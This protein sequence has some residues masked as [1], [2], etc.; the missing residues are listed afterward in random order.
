MKIAVE[1]STFLIKN[2]TGVEHYT[3]RLMQAVL[4]LDRSNTYLMTYMAFGKRPIPDFNLSASNVQHRRVRWLPGKLYNLFLRLPFGLPIDVI[5]GIKPD[6]FFFPNF[7]LWPLWQTKRSVIVIHDL[8]Y[9]ELPEVLKTGHHVWFLQKSITR[10]IKKASRVVAVSEHT[11]RQISKYYGVPLNEIAVVSPSLDKNAFRPA[12]D[13]EIK[14]FKKRHGIRDNYI[15]YF[16]TLEPRKNI[17]GLIRSYRLLPAELRAKYQLVLAGGKGWG[18]A[19]I[20][21]ELSLLQPGE[22]V[23]TGYVPQDE[24]HVVYSG[25]TVFVYASRYEGWGMQTLEAM[26][27]GTPVI[28]ADNSSLPEVGG[29]AALYF[30]S[31]D[32]TQLVAA[33]QRVLTDAK[34]RQQMVRKGY[35]H[36]KNFS[37]QRSAENL[38]KVFKDLQ[39]SL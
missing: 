4:E 18:S 22:L 30:K 28:S 2:K 16:G 24:A 23:R 34:L 6:I 7:V 31:G 26:A 32:D 36:C 5:A 1:S 19:E 14:Q 39:S 25:A 38:L 37:W 29:D 10:S 27:C 13:V 8:A 17:V 15:L 35:A 20:D 11:K 3:Q 9:L 21:H 12:S 33:L